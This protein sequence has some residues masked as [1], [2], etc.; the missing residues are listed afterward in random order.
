VLGRVDGQRQGACF[1]V[2][3]VQRVAADAGD[4]HGHVVTSRVRMKPD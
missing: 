1:A 4:V 2:L 3:A